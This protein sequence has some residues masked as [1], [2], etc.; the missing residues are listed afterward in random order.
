[1]N[2]PLPYQKLERH[3]HEPARLAVLCRLVQEPQGISFPN[4]SRELDLTYGNLERHL[5]VLGDAGIITTEK[6]PAKRRPLSIVKLTPSG[7]GA[8]L[9]YLD[10][11]QTVLQSATVARGQ[12]TQDTGGTPL[13]GTSLAR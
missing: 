5:K 2:D 12:P 6:V 10:H 4:L 9:D 1:M 3:F 7:H 13:P 11:L 8:F